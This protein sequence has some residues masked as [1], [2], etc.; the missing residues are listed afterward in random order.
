MNNKGLTDRAQK[1]SLYGW[2]GGSLS[3]I[4]LELYELAGGPR[5]N[6]RWCRC[7][8]CPMPAS[9]WTWLRAGA[10]QRRHKPALKVASKQALAAMPLACASPASTCLPT[11]AAA[12]IG[13]CPRRSA[14]GAGPPRDGRRVQHATGQVRGLLSPLEC[15]FF[16]GRWLA[17]PFSC[18]CPGSSV[19][20]RLLG[21]HALLRVG[22]PPCRPAPL[23][24]APIPRCRLRR[25]RPEINRRLLTLIHA[26]FQVRTP[27]ACCWLSL[28]AFQPFLH[29]RPHRVCGF[30][31]CWPPWAVAAAAP[32]PATIPGHFGSSGAASPPRPRPAPQA[33][34]AMGLLELRPWSPRTVGAIGTVTSLM[35]CYM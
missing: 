30:A 24:H 33:A 17:C 22:P 35:N 20:G 7:S 11:R 8:C 10:V 6:S 2:F 9:R 29:L 14:G 1:A 4:A 34:L 28:G 32:L 25:A 3:T 19:H 26:C 5:F 31:L 16:S 15:L 23:Q 18:C 21:A 27:L 12:G 13:P